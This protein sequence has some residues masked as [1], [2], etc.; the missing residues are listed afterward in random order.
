MTSK[1]CHWDLFSVDSGGAV[2]V[3]GLEAAQS[4]A[5]RVQPE[6]DNRDRYG[7]TGDYG[8]CHQDESLPDIFPIRMSVPA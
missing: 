7:D 6:H 8:G 3:A 1:K 2:L 5:N 4:A